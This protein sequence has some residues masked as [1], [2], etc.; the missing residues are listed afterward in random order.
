M[1]KPKGPLRDTFSQQQ[2]QQSTD[3]IR[4]AK[5]KSLITFTIPHTKPGALADALAVFKT[6]SF[7]LTSIDTRPSR[8]RNW[9]YVFFVECE[10]ADNYTAGNGE[11][12]PEVEDNLKNML[13]HLEKFTER[14]R[15]LGRFKDQ[16]ET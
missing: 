10:E 16:L 7:N 4:K 2:Q 15:Y 8:K 12:G 3:T 14:L 5:Y 9:Q 13:T 1:R 11:A 6:H